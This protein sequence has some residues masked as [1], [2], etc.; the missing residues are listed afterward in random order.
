V[1]KITE[2]YYYLPSGRL[3]HRRDDSTVWGVDPTPGY[4]V[5]VTTDET[6]EMLRARREQEIIDQNEAAEQV[7]LRDTPAVLEALNDLQLNAAVEVMQE[8]VNSGEFSPA[9]IEENA[10]T[11]VALAELNTLRAQEERLLRELTRLN[12]RMDAAEQEVPDDIVAQDPRDFWA[13]ET[14]LEGGELVVRD[15]DGNIIATLEITGNNLEAWLIDA[16]VEKKGDAPTP[17]ESDS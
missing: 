8:R 1:L 4:F 5:P 3:L 12:R 7:D 17:E 6:I 10:P 13:D 11:D 14:D 16:D 2:Q 15:A 9:G